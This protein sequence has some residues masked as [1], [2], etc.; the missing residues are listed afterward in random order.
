MAEQKL[1]LESV[2]LRQ[3]LT[4]HGRPLESIREGSVLSLSMSGKHLLV[5]NIE[6]DSVEEVYPGAIAKV[7]WVKE[8]T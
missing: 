6:D 7:R 4:I 8:A 1:K 5:K 2:T 3:K